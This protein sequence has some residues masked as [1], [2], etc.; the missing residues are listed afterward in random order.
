MELIAGPTNIM[1]PMSKIIIEKLDRIQI[2]LIKHQSPWRT[3][4]E[5]ADYMGVSYRTMQRY[6]KKG[7]LN[8]HIAPSGIIRIN[9]N[10][11]DAWLMFGR[12]F[13]KLTR[14][15]KEQLRELCQ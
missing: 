3:V 5:A 1:H 4:S 13:R 10:D 11:I 15:Q 6:I 8:S 2:L 7:I 9:Q 14:P 12:A